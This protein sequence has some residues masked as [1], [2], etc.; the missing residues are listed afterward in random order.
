VRLGNAS[1][2]SIVFYLVA[3]FWSSAFA[4]QLQ[5][6]EES[7]IRVKAQIQS[8]DLRSAR[9]EL[10]RAAL[11]FP[12]DPRVYNFLGVV[13]A[14]AKNFASAESNFR[15]AIHAAPQFP[16]PYLNLG[17]LYQENSVER[18][19]R[20]R[21]LATYQGLLALKADHAEANF[22]A[23]SLLTELGSY[24]ASL[25]H[26]ARLP[27]EFQQLPAGSYIVRARRRGLTSANYVMQIADEDSRGITLKLFA[28]PR[29]TSSRDS[30]VAS[31]YG[32]TDAHFDAFDRRTRTDA[33]RTV[34]GAGDLFRADG[35]SLDF[36]L[37]QYRDQNAMRRRASA[38][39]REGV[40]STDDGDCLLIDGKRGAYQPLRSFRSTDVQ[41]VEVFR[42]N[43]FVDSYVLSQ[44]QSLRE[45]DGSADHHPGY[46]VLWT[47]ALR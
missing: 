43:A 5:P 3:A 11:R 25:K 16:D 20:E 40:G 21:A 37:H 44:M 12:G 31:G 10:E 15:K 38:T 45:C 35:A 13:E 4:G 36:V 1:S 46:F 7:L 29:R 6:V 27:A 42:A 28:L 8:G 30:A 26:L 39:V 24:K 17:R 47:R 18:P 23:A 2:L 41:L 33:G 34:F 22:Q 19:A 9:A 14:Q 32:V